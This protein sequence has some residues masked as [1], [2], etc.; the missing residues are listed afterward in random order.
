MING[1]HRNVSGED[2]SRVAA[3]TCIKD[4]Q[5]VE[6]DR[7]SVFLNFASAF[8]FRSFL[9]MQNGCRLHTNDQKRCDRVVCHR[10]HSF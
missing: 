10:R 5:S 8:T 3:P 1:L 2:L 7:L 4:K 6:S 9:M